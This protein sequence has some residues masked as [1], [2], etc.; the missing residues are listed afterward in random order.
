MGACTLLGAAVEIGMPPQFFRSGK[1]VQHRLEKLFNASGWD[2]LSAMQPVP[3]FAQGDW[4]AKLEE[5]L[6]R[7]ASP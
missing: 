3:P 1:P 5:V 4:K 2:I 6:V 7:I